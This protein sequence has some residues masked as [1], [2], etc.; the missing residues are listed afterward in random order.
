MYL[1]PL[2]LLLAFMTGLLN[3]WHFLVKGKS[4]CKMQNIIFLFLMFQVM[5]FVLEGFFAEMELETAEK[6]E[7]EDKV[8]T[9]L[10]YELLIYM[11]RL[12]SQNIFI[13]L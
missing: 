10:N 3:T 9:F 8:G 4:Y 12:F 5:A 7:A 1:I 11:C 2:M 13:C 6:C